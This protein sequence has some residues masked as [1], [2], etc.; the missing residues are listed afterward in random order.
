MCTLQFIICFLYYLEQSSEARSLMVLPA[1]VLHSTFK[2]SV[3]VLSVADVDNVVIVSMFLIEIICN[4]LDT[5]PI[6]F[7]ESCGRKCHGDNV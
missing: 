3:L 5:I 4:V 1:I 6:D 2:Q 7:L